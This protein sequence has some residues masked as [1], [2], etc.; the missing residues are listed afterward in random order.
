[1]DRYPNASAMAFELRRIA[2][3]MGVGDGR[4]F[5]RRALDR[6]FGNDASEVTAER[7]YSTAPPPLAAPA[8]RGAVAPAATRTSRSRP[9]PPRPSPVRPDDLLDLNDL[10]A[11]PTIANDDLSDH[12]E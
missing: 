6:D 7:P 8:A 2:L 10:D 11:M 3:A 9:A 4:L 5:L 1:V 12:R